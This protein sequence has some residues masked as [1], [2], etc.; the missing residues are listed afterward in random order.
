MYIVILTSTEGGNPLE[1]QYIQTVTDILKDLFIVLRLLRL[2]P[3]IHP[4]T[5]YGKYCYLSLIEKLSRFL[6]FL[7]LLFLLRAYF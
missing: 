6:N 2:R 4:L 1:K 7:L 5:S 3:H